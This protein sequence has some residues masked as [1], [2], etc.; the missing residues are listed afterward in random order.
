MKLLALKLLRKKKRKLREK[1]RR[2]KMMILINQSNPKTKFNSKRTRSIL[3]LQGK[4]M[5][6]IADRKLQRLLQ[7]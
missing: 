4:R 2:K 5:M 1:K 3:F 6:P 7:L